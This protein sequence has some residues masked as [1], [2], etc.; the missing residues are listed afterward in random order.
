M[1]SNLS[2]STAALLL[3]IICAL[4]NFFGD[5]SKS[6]Q[7]FQVSILTPILF[8]PIE[9]MQHLPQVKST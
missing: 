9:H 7:S 4:I 2:T 3:I 6:H 8:T 1:G 5:D